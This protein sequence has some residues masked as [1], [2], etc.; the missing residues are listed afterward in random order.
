MEFDPRS[1]IIN[2]VQ[3]EYTDFEALRE[4]VVSKQTI[5]S[6]MQLIELPELN[7]TKHIMLLQKIGKCVADTIIYLNDAESLK[8]LLE[9]IE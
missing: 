3:T 1:R 4:I 8:T 9:K 7:K 6:L 2:Q 5:Q